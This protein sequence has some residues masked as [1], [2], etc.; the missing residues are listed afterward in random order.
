MTTSSGLETLK[1]KHGFVNPDVLVHPRL[2]LAASA[3]QKRGKTH[4]SLTA[5]KPLV[6]YNMDVGLEGVVH[7][8]SKYRD[9]ILEYPLPVPDMVRRNEDSA[10]DEAEKIWDKFEASFDDTIRTSDIRTVVV[11]TAT[12]LWELLRLARF[13]SLNK[14]K[15]FGK[16]AAKFAYGPVNAE[17][18]RFLRQILDKSDKNLILLHKMKAEYI[19][20]ERTGNWERA[21]FS[22]IDFIAQ[23]V[24]ELD[25]I[26][27]TPDDPE[28]TFKLT[29]VDS[30]HN[31][32]VNGT[33]LTDPMCNFPFLASMIIEGTTPEDWGYEEE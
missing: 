14:I 21:G 12:E 13:G 1:R 19:A 28:T 7:K 22:D 3:R 30:R 25:R 4:F 24:I 26:N 8:F 11:D 15:G 27:P 33:E 29:V 32:T 5:P 20:N 23:A 9:Q 18:R 17:F 6:Y 16:D 31:P 10:Q 2:I